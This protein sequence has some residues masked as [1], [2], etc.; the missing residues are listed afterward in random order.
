MSPLNSG[1]EDENTKNTD[2]NTEK[3]DNAQENVVVVGKGNNVDVEETAENEK[4]YRYQKWRADDEVDLVNI[5][6]DSSYYRDK[7]IFTNSKHQSNQ[8]WYSEISREISK[9]QETRGDEIIHYLPN[10]VRDKF[11]K[12]VKKCRELVCNN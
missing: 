10:K 4:S 3:R 12:M 6:C 1:D 5:I 7:L 8:R 11:K 9:L 2:E